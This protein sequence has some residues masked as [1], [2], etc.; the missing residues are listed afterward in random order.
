MNVS[1]ISLMTPAQG[2]TQAQDRVEQL[3]SRYQDVASDLMQ[4]G[5]SN[6]YMQTFLGNQARFVELVAESEPTGGDAK[7][8]VRNLSAEDR[9]VLQQVHS[10]GSVITDSNI[11]QMSGEGAANLLR[12]RGEGQDSNN[13]GVT[14]SGT[15][16]IFKFPNSNTPSNV[17]SAWNRSMDGLSEK[18]QMLATSAVMTEFMTA[19]MGIDE[20]GKVK[21]ADPGDIDWVNPFSADFSY[22]EWAQKRLDYLD[23]FKGSIS[24]EQYEGGKR[25]TSAFLAN[26]KAEGAA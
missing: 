5:M 24:T 9:A 12:M 21:R 23:A 6:D 7:A 18:D 11:D 25:F 8:F 2:S 22:Q 4:R 10:L 26:L 19:N 14:D 17:A 13:D 1:P 16:Q 20:N 3:N 15:V